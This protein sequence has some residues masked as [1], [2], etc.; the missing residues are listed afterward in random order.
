MCPACHGL[1]VSVCLGN[2]AVGSRMTN[3]CP[4]SGSWCAA[5]GWLLLLWAC[6]GKKHTRLYAY[7][8]VLWCSCIPQREPDCGWRVLTMMLRCWRCSIAPTLHCGTMDVHHLPTPVL[9][10]AHRCHVNTHGAQT[11]RVGGG[12]RCFAAAHDSNDKCCWQLT[13]CCWCDLVL[14]GYKCD[15][16]DYMQANR[17]CLHARTV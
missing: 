8:A 11:Q 1:C 5:V 14:G 4:E 17:C 7:K 13:W 10:P 6:A 3:G 16:G 15:V 12:C 9:S 2:A